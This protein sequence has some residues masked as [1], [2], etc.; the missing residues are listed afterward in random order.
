MG[1]KIVKKTSTNKTS[2]KDMSTSDLYALY[3]FVSN[4]GN[5]RGFGMTSPMAK[6]VVR[7]KQRE[8]EQELYLRAYGYNPFEEYKQEF[9]GM[10]PED[11]DLDKVV[12]YSGP[13][14]EPEDK[15]PQTFVVA[16]RPK[17]EGEGQ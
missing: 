10:K 17:T 6:A 1:K 9:H 4:D 11:I 3:L 8:I 12:V 13:D 14:K 7:E 15:E 16:K 2:I 5:N